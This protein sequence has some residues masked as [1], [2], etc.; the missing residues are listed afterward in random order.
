MLTVLLVA[1]FLQYITP[2]M[3]GGEKRMQSYE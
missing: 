2:I 3:R 1:E